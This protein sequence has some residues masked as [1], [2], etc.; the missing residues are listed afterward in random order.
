MVALTV[1]P[2]MLYPFIRVAGALTGTRLIAYGAMSCIGM[3]A[4]TV[5]APRWF[6]DGWAEHARL[7]LAAAHWRAW[8]G[9]AAAG[10][11][12]ICIPIGVLVWRGAMAIVPAAPGN[13]WASTGLAVLMLAPA[14]LSEE[15]M[16]RGYAF[17]LLQRAWGAGTAMVGTS[18]LF[19]LLHVLNPDVS[20]QAI[21]MVG[22]AGVF[23]ALVRLAFDSLWAAWMAHLAYNTVQL[24]VFHAPVSGLAVEQPYYRLVPRGATWLTGGAWGPEAGVGAAFGMLGVSI[25]LSLYA[26]WLRVSRRNGRFVIEWRPAGRREP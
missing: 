14:A 6:G 16:M 4:A 10:W 5:L 20:A 8:L 13:W 19:A 22:L 9:G 17:T 7:D 11:F 18:A 25:L 24:A 2:A 26:G 1:V 21:V 23:L 3:I 12:A 15:L